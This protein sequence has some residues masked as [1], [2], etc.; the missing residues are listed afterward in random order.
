MADLHVRMDTVAIAKML[1]TPGGPVGRELLRRGKQAE[2]VAKQ[3]APK[4]MRPYISADL[5]VGKDA[6]ELELRC[7]HPATLYVINGTKPHEIRPKKASV[8]HFYIAGR[9]VFATV[10]H[11]PGT[12]A[13]DFLG[14]A[15]LT[16]RI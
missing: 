15:L 6:V 16:A 7:S 4:G 10:V 14:K 2:F 5:T 8:L 9:E 3:L 13:N 12:K 1:R 11:H